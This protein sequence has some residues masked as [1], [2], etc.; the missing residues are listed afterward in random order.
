[1]ITQTYGSLELGYTSRFRFLWNDQQSGANED[2]A[3]WLPEQQPGV[4]GEWRPLGAVC[5]RDYQDVNGHLGGLLIRA[6]PGAEQILAPPTTS[7]NA[8][9]SARA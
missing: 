4:I 9:A 6:G 7:P 2:G 5:V 1:M 8:P 3:F